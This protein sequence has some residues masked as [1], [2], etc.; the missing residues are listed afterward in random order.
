MLEWK[1]KS[2]GKTALL[3]DGA[4]RIGKSYLCEEFGKNEY[5]SYLIIDFGNISKEIVD[6]FENESSN[7]YCTQNLRHLRWRV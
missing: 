1:E 4:R 3:I 2:Q 5:K 7:L 6:L